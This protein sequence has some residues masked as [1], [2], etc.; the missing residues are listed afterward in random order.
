MHRVDG[1]LT[2][3]L[4]AVAH[5]ACKTRLVVLTDAFYPPEISQTQHTRARIN[6]RSRTQL[7]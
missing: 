7:R 2:K 6:D 5:R 3:H 4:Y 1:S